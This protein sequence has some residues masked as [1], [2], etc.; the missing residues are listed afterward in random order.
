LKAEQAECPVPLSSSVIA[1]VFAAASFTTYPAFD[2]PGSRVEAVIDRGPILE[3]V[4]RCAGGTGILSFSKIDR[5]YC[6][7]DQR[8]AAGLGTAISRLCK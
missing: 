8:C 6:T 4:V 3:M 1:G 2:R 7:P 5:K